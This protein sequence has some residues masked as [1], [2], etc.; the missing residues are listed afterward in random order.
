MTKFQ[1]EVVCGDLTITS[2]FVGNDT[3][4]VTI[5]DDISGKHFSFRAC[6]DE[7]LTFLHV[8]MFVNLDCVD[9]DVPCDYQVLLPIVAH[10]MDGCPEECIPWRNWPA[11]WKEVL[12]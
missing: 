10:L 9:G 11:D 5:T 4:D 12:F 6:K 7:L 2:T 3:H 8:A 1:T